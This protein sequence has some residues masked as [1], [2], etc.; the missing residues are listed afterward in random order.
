MSDADDAFTP[1][2]LTELVMTQAENSAQ[3]ART[4]QLWRI[5]RWP[6]W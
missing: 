6:P 2:Q 3:I 1:E 5:N 4:W